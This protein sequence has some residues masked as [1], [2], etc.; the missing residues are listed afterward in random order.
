MNK[1]PQQFPTLLAHLVAR[2]QRA[3]KNS[4]ELP[5]LGL[6]LTATEEVKLL[7]GIPSP[8]T[9]LKETLAAIQDNL[10]GL[11]G[12]GEIE[13][14]CIAYPDYED[15]TVVAYLENAEQYCIRYC[16]PVVQDADARSLG[17][18]DIREEDGSIFIFGNAPETDA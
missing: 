10:Q 17:I 9:G 1:S 8:E 6:G 14:A 5:A 18:K 13:A 16:I 3:L 11:A 15:Q 7:L 2:Y 12:H 4:G